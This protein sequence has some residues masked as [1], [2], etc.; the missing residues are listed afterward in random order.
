MNERRVNVEMREQFPSSASIFGGNEVDVF[1][2]FNRAERHV[3]EVADRRR[4]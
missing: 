2:N 3:V 1:Q 4:A